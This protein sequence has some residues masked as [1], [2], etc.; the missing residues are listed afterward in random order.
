LGAAFWRDLHDEVERYSADPDCEMN[1]TAL[2]DR[3]RRD[4]EVCSK[5]DHFRA[6][7]RAVTLYAFMRWRRLLR[8][9]QPRQIAVVDEARAD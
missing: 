3:V 2:R 4:G 5:L 6:L 1:P 9:Q 8:R 7:H